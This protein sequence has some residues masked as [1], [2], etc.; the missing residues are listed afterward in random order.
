[1]T[2]FH[3]PSGGE[4]EPPR[5]DAPPSL[6]KRSFAFS[7]ALH[8][9]L[10]AATIAAGAFSARPKKDSPRDV[11]VEFTVAVPPQEETAAED[12]PAPDPP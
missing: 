11:M 2:P 3:A 12:T 5:K 8:A 6:A 1:M 7:V 10:V 4:T 9:A